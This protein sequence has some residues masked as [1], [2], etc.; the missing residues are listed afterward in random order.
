MEEEKKTWSTL[1]E[2]FVKLM[3]EME[4]S[5]H[6]IVMYTIANKS[7]QSGRESVTNNINARLTSLEDYVGGDFEDSTDNYPTIAIAIKE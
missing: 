6:L 4:E 1:P 2:S 7:M 3:Q 5:M